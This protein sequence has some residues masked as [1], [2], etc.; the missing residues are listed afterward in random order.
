MNHLL[1]A[2]TLIAIVI[3]ADSFK[4]ANR[5]D[6]HVKAEGYFTAK[7]DGKLFDSRSQDNYTAEVSSK[8]PAHPTADITFFGNNYADAS[9]NIF[10][11]S[12][13]FK[14][15]F[16]ERATGS[17]PDQKI[18]FQFDNQKFLSVPG[19]TQITVTKMQWNPDGNSY[20]VSADF[21][22][23]MVKW[24]APGQDQPIVTV[25]GRMENINVSVPASFKINGKV[26]M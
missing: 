12:L 7:I 19:Q 11:E 4:L 10:Q 16:G 20:V 15:A 6:T 3:F 9:G 22:G 24:A 18:V 26:N 8:D 21:Q 14:Y 13:E 25:K 17:V 2:F 1:K 5:P 23:K